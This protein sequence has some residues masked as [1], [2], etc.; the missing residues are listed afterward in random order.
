M[1]RSRVRLLIMLVCG[2]VAALGLQVVG[3]VPAAAIP[4]LQNVTASSAVNSNVYKPVTATCP[5]GKVVIGGGG[6]LTFATGQVSITYLAPTPSGNGY[7]AR[8]Y[9]DFDGYAGA[10]GLTVTAICANIP[11]GYE[12]KTATSP[13]GSPPTASATA[14]CSAGRLVLGT[15]GAVFPGRGWMVLTSILPTPT[16]GT[17]RVVVGAAEIQGGYGSAWDVSAWAICANPVG[18]HVLTST[19][20]ASN[21]LSPKTQQNDCPT[22][23]PVHG[24]GFVFGGAGVGEVFLNAAY[25][26]PAVPVGTAVPVTA[27]ED[28]SGVLGSWDVRSYAIC[29]T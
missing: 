7:E 16:T 15:G 25:P 2:L 18:G 29:A 1:V 13:S 9:E 3:A 5:A 8:A 23:R 14:S 28:Q 6:Q 21:S 11:P 19:P 17:D 4:G 10:W 20:S 12:I 24:V 26:T 27:S 22:G